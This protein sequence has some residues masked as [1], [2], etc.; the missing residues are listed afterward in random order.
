MKGY[1]I[2][3]RFYPMFTKWKSEQFFDYTKGYSGWV[4]DDNIEDLAIECI[5]FL[6]EYDIETF[7]E[8]LEITFD[9]QHELNSIGL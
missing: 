6:L 4:C 9:L 7:E 5:E 1:K 2:W 3:K 8:S